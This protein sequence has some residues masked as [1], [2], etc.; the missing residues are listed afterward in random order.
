MK[1][2][3]EQTSMITHILVKKVTNMYSNELINLLKGTMI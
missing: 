1:T 2:I 3:L